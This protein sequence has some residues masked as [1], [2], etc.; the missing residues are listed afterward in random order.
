ME[1]TSDEPPNGDTG[2]RAF[3]E[4]ADRLARFHSEASDAVEK[5]ATA[6]LGFSGVALTLIPLLIDAPRRPISW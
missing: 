1:G 3:A 4:I 6:I 2:A 5:K